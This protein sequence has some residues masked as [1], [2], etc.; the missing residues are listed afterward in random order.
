MTTALTFH[1]DDPRGNPRVG[2]NNKSLWF[3]SEPAVFGW[4]KVWLGLIVVVVCRDELIFVAFVSPAPSALT[5]WVKG[6]LSTGLLPKSVTHD[7]IP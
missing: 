3:A 1:D 6:Y 2:E 5:D 4:K 7:S